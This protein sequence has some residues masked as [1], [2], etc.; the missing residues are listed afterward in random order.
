VLL[1]KNDQPSEFIFDALR[2]VF[3]INWDAL[4]WRF[5]VSLDPFIV[6]VGMLVALLNIFHRNVMSGTKGHE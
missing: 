3:G 4:D 1:H 2:V 5:Q 6:Y